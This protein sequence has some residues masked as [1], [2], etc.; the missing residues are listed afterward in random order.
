MERLVIKTLPLLV[1]IFSLSG[2]WSGDKFYEL[3]ESVAG[4][5]AG[6]YRVVDVGG[7]ATFDEHAG[8][9]KKL[10]IRYETDGHVIVENIGEANSNNAVLVKLGNTPGLYMVQSDLGARLPGLWSAEFL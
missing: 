8:F 4:I 7:V 6:H 5:P 1:L 10:N 9:G 2:C 3:S